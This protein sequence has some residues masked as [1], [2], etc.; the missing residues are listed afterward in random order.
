MTWR[1]LGGCWSGLI[2]ASPSI[3]GH[4]SSNSG[5]RD[6]TSEACSQW[7]KIFTPWR[8]AKMTNQGI[9]TPPPPPENL[10][11]NINQPTASLNTAILLRRIG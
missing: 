11:F 9:P 1:M 2:W 6:I 7:C 5:F 8:S 10:L 3:S 4:L